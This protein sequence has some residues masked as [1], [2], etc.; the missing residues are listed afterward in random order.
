MFGK[1]IWHDLAATDTV[2]AIDFYRAVFG[3]TAV[4]ENANGGQFIRLQHEGQDIGSMYSLSQRER[5]YSVPSHWT[6]YIS[7]ENS[8]LTVSQVKAAGGAILVEPF[9]VGS[10][11]RIA[12]ITDNIGSVMGLWESLV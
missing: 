1:F 9:V 5:Q 2:A 4:A 11:A 6:P 3:W 12:L 10:T 8:G 7:V